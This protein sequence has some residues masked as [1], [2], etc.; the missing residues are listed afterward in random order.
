MPARFP[1]DR[2]AHRSTPRGAGPSP[3]GSTGKVTMTIQKIAQVLEVAA[4]RRDPPLV[5]EEEAPVREVIRLMR[6]RALCSAAVTKQE[7]L[8]E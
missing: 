5:V 6:D 1:G 3:A 7:R 2:I 8:V 4:L